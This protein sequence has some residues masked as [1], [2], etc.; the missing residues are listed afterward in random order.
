[1][2]RKTSTKAPSRTPQY[3]DLEDMPLGPHRACPFDGLFWQ[4]EEI[5][6]ALDAGRELP[7]V[8]LAS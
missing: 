7:T 4:V 1:M 8:R 2:T 6:A 3:A 5:L